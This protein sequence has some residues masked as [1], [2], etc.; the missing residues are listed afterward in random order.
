MRVVSS[1]GAG[2]LVLSSISY[3]DEYQGCRDAELIQLGHEVQDVFGA[4]YCLG[5]VQGARDMAT[6]HKVETGVGSVCVPKEKTTIEL[7]M[8]FNGVSYQAREYPLSGAISGFL[9]INY[10]CE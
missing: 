7:V 1:I 4:A 3:G 10:P 8:E 2:L 6:L 9:M 5:I